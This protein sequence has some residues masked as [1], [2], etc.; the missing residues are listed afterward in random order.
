MSLM[1]YKSSCGPKYLTR[2]RQDQ[3]NCTQFTI[4]TVSFQLN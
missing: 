1:W 4:T 2:L 3:N